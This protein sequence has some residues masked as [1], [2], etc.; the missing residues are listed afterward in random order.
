MRLLV[1]TLVLAAAAAA[2]GGAF[3]PEYEYEEEL[4][5]ALDSSATLNVY[6]S[7]ASLA[8]LRGLPLDPDPRARIDLDAVRALFG[9]PAVPVSVSLSRRDGRRFVNVSVD[10]DDVR[11]LPRLA[12]FAWSSYRF[13]RR[14]D[15]L[16]FRQTVGAAGIRDPGSR[17]SGSGIR[18]SWTGGELVAFRIHLPSEIV[19][20]NAPSGEILRGNILVWEQ[21]LGDRLAGRP[22][23]LQVNL[24]PTSILARTLLLFA[25]TILAAAAALAGVIWWIR[26]QETPNPK[27]QIP[28]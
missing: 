20:H 6:A 7:A 4:Y 16:E 11:T 12:P 13:D 25:G 5:L 9:A 14:G 17:D 27:S 18:R 26:S 15:V 21:P 28:N 22:L 10:V 19:L 2:C 23:E 1:L 3:E 24:E 8:A